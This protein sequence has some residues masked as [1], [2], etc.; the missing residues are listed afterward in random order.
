MDY[1][2]LMEIIP[3]C[4]PAGKDDCRGCQY[5]EGVR[6]GM[7]AICNYDEQVKQEEQ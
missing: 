7:D 1:I 5:F 3:Y 4:C 2:E 6:W